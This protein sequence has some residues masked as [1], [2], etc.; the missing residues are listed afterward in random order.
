MSF[1]DVDRTGDPAS[2]VGC[3]DRLAPL[4]RPLTHRT[5]ELLA[6]GEGDCILDVGCGTGEAARAL[7]RQVG[8]TGRVVGVDRSRV[9]IREARRRTEGEPLPVEYRLGDVYRL[10]FADGTFDGCRAERVLM[11]LNHPGTA[12]AEM[13]RVVRRGGRIVV[14]ET[15]SRTR[16]LDVPNQDVTQRILNHFGNQF[17][18][19]WMGRQLPRLF[20]QAGLTEIGVFPHTAFTTDPAWG[21]WGLSFREAADSAQAAGVVSATEAADW[22]D[23]IRDAEQTGE[24]FNALTC[25][26]VCGCKP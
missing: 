1:E 8:R 11:H 24:I 23:Q 19:T 16:V 3:L 26:V 6:V 21:L 25:Y 2:L 20:R 22:L 12:L 17:P 18:N 13:C 10:D 5:F 9:M 4:F 15:D 7:A 14:A